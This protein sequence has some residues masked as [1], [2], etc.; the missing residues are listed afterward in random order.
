[1]RST[2]RPFLAFGAYPSK[3]LQAVCL[4]MLALLVGLAASQPIMAQE[5]TTP[6]L[7]RPLVSVVT[8]E[9]SPEAVEFTVFGA[10]SAHYQQQLTSEV[11]GRV[12][13]LSSQ[14]EPGLMLKKGDVLAEIEDSSY[15]AALATAEENVASSELSL[16]QEEQ[17]GKQA[18]LDWERANIKGREASP[19]VLRKPFLKQEQLKLKAAA[20]NLVEAQRNLANTRIVA[21][22]DAVV[23]SRSIAPSSYVTAGTQIAEIYSTDTLDVEVALT[24]VQWQLLLTEKG[25]SLSVNEISARVLNEA[26]VEWPAKITSIGATANAQTRQQSLRLQIEPRNAQ[27]TVM[28]PGTFVRVM[29]IGREIPDIVMVPASAITSQGYVWTVS[30]DSQLERHLVTPLFTRVDEVALDVSAF[31]SRGPWEIVVNPI[32]RYLPQQ[33]VTTQAA[34]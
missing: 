7:P 34:E 8:R 22:F 27:G 31:P 25:N 14:L 12:V 32:S 9:A 21:P 4:S 17:R 26:G 2:L 20:A 24:P 5:A 6:T 15:R 3:A 16:L 13:G 10:V 30:D 23:I 1:M 33:I 29:L 18:E 28:R 19:L 11:T